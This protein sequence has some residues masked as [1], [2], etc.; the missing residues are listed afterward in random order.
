MTTQ[1]LLILV[2]DLM[3]KFGGNVR[4]G[5]NGK[6]PLQKDVGEEIVPIV[7]GGKLAIVIKE[8]NIKKGTTS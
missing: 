1:N 7:Q 3:R 6:L 2:M 5:M 8:T 4:M